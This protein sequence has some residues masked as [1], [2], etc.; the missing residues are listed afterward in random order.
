MWKKKH[1]MRNQVSDQASEEPEERDAFQMYMKE[2]PKNDDKECLPE[3]IWKKNPRM[4]WSRDQTSE[5]R[6]QKLNVSASRPQWKKGDRTVVAGDNNLNGGVIFEFTMTNP[7]P[8]TGKTW[9]AYQ[10]DQQSR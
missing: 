2:E 4:L 1:P 5:E 10:E 7:P 6:R 8:N 3:V 9:N